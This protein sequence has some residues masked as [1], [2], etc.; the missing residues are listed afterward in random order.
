MP[1]DLLLNVPEVG[2]EVA[3]LLEQR[4]QARWM[5]VLAHGAGA[6]MRH[7]FMENLARALADG[8]VAIL[9]YFNGFP[10]H[11]PGRQTGVSFPITCWYRCLHGRLRCGT[12]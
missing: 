2:I 5:L 3:A 1:C 10:I 12:I 8:G 9:G 6:G 11:Q 4:P 7:A